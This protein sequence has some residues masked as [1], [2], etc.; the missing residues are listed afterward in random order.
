MKFGMDI[1]GTQRMC[2]NDFGHPLTY[3]V[4]PT[5]GQRFHSSNEISQR[6]SYELAQNFHSWFPDDAPP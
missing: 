4:A 1:H 6:L 5:A 3:P 2:A